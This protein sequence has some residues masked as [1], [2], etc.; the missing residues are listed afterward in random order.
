MNRSLIRVVKSSLN[1]PRTGG[2][3]FKSIWESFQEWRE[4]GKKK[5]EEKRKK[6]GEKGEKGEREEN[7][8]KGTKKEVK[9]EVWWSKKGNG[10]KKNAFFV[11]I[12]GAFQIDLGRLSRSMGQYMYTHLILLYIYCRTWTAICRSKYY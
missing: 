4:E 12:F 11:K 3:D 10:K 1:L 7:K 5:N 9:I 6:K 8:T 2:G